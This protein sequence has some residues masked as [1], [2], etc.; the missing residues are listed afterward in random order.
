MRDLRLR[1]SG[2]SLAEHGRGCISIASPSSFPPGAAIVVG[3]EETLARL[4]TALLGEHRDA[5]C[6]VLAQRC[7]DHAPVLPPQRVRAIV[8]PE[9]RIYF[10]TSDHLLRKLRMRLGSALMVSRGAVRI[11]WPGL[12]VQSE[13]FAHPLV[14]VLDDEPLE[15]ALAEVA[16]QFDL[17]RPAVRE[18]LK[19]VEDAR[20]VLEGEVSR[21][22]GDL[23]E[24]A[25]QLS[26]ASN[27]RSEAITRAET[28]ERQLQSLS[29]PRHTES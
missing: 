13:P 16:R 6:I 9:P 25:R 24:M 28:A 21:L 8:G 12:S 10:I 14:P 26:Q 22:K 17:S 2:A 23:G 18:E 5:P 19:L 1:A 7:D 27:Q 3:D 4:E 15:S 20:A 11:F 29:G